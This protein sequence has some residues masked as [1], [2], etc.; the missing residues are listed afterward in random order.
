MICWWLKAI[1]D[2]YFATLF[3]YRYHVE[4]IEYDYGLLIS[5]NWHSLI[6]IMLIH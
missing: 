4:V 5:D 2:V 3:D 6:I 1:K